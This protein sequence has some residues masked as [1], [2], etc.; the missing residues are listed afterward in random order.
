TP[1]IPSRRSWEATSRVRVRGGR[2]PEEKPPGNV[3]TCELAPLTE[4]QPSMRHAQG[5]RSRNG[6]SDQRLHS[7][8]TVGDGAALQVF[9]G[10]RHAHARPSVRPCGYGK[11]SAPR[12]A[13]S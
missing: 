13:H 9:G 6:S 10:V 2:L 7:R 12:P 8:I 1:V 4:Y 3:P 11:G 5:A